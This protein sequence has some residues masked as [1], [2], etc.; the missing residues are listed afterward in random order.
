[1]IDTTAPIDSKA[2][3]G[4]E[5]RGLACCHRRLVLQGASR[6]CAT[7]PDDAAEVSTAPNDRLMIAD[8]YA[9]SRCIAPSSSTGTIHYAAL[10]MGSLYRDHDGHGA[11][12]RGTFTFGK[13]STC[14]SF[15][16]SLRPGGQHPGMHRTSESAIDIPGNFP[17]L[18]EKAQAV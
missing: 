6:P 1:M 13:H 14:A 2:C 17:M 8:P 9:L 4:S 7:L 5:G 18:H 12:I 15:G 16:H 11:C 3:S 10:T